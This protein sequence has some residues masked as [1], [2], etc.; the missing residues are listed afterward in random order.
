MTFAQ[1]GYSLL[2]NTLFLSFVL[3]AFSSCEE[4]DDYTPMEEQEE[5]IDDDMDD[6]DDMGTDSTLSIDINATPFDTLAEYGFFEGTMADLNPVNGVLEYSLINKLFSDYSIKKRFVW[7]P[8][9]VTGAFDGDDSLID[10]P[11][12]TIL[13]KNFYYDNVMPTND[14]RIIET[15]LLIHK[16]TGWEFADYVWNDN[17]TAAV[18]NL[19]GSTVPISWELNGEMRTVDYRIP[20]AG[21]C[22]T[23]HKSGDTSIPIGPKP[24]N[25]NMMMA[26]ADGSSLNQLEK[27]VETGYLQ[28]FPDTVEALV[29]WTNES[30]PLESRVRGYFEVNCAHCHIDN[31]HCSYRPIRLNYTES[32]DPENI[33]ICVVPEED[34]GNGLTRIIDPGNINRSTLFYRLNTTAEEVRMPLL[35]RTL[36]HDEAITLIEDYINELTQI[37]D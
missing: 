9:G 25:L 28:S 3:F 32:S 26:Y 31:G 10:M 12:G 35:G 21:E 23:C 18:Y 7:M 34:L 16:N 27:W 29:S 13:I 2:I 5:I 8:E 37:C 15:R 20:N 24:Q 19:D 4:N 14:R 11:V 17:Q 30:A 22:Q 6:D 1:K 33:G 36:I